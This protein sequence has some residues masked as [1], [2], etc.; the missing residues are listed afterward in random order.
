M[1]FSLQL[2]ANPVRRGSFP[3]QEI[4]IQR[5]LFNEYALEQD[6]LKK[7]KDEVD[8]KLFQAQEL[9]DRR[10]SKTVIKNLNALR[11]KVGLLL[12]RGSGIRIT[13][14]DSTTIVRKNFSGIN[15]NLVLSSDLRDLVNALFLQ[16]AVAISINAIRI[17][18]LTSIQSVGDGMLIGNSFQTPPFIIE[19]V[20]DPQALKESVEILKNRKIQIFVDEEG[21]FEIPP[22]QTVRSIQYL[23][24]QPSS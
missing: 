14:R 6:D 21:T 5:E 2:R 9:I 24:I 7:R 23:K 22:V 16:D 1:I 13:L 17:M 19:A 12:I 4:E 15:E 11:M 18:P 20:G 10:T 8:Q 3:L